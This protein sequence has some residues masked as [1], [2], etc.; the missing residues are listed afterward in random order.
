[1]KTIMLFT[2]TSQLFPQR[3][4]DQRPMMW[5]L[6]LADGRTTL[7]KYSNAALVL[8]VSNFEGNVSPNI[9]SFRVDLQDE[10]TR[11][12]CSTCYSRLSDK[13]TLKLLLLFVRVNTLSTELFISIS[14]YCGW[15]GG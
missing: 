12:P 9:T 10:Y 5:T 4:A 15:C 14:V 7:R 1:M 2:N 3:P 8:P 13:D 6:T 11:P